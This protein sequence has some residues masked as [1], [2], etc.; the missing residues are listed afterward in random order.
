MDSSQLNQAANVETV[1][2]EEPSDKVQVL[3]DEK[4]CITRKHLY[5]I[6]GVLLVAAIALIGTLLGFSSS[7]PDQSIN[8]DT[9]RAGVS[10][11]FPML[12]TNNDGYVDRNEVGNWMGA[13]IASCKQN[14]NGHNGCD[15]SCG[16]TTV[17]T[18]DPSTNNTVAANSEIDSVITG[19]DFDHNGKISHAE[20]T[21]CVI[22][23]FIHSGPKS[24]VQPSGR[25]EESG[26]TTVSE[27]DVAA[28]EGGVAT[29]R[30]GRKPTC[31]KGLK[32]SC[33]Q[34]FGCQDRRKCAMSIIP[35]DALITE[36]CCPGSG[37]GLNCTECSCG[38]SFN[39]LSATESPTIGQLCHKLADIYCGDRKTGGQCKG[40]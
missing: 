25:F 39:V 23:A 18:E 33:F 30:N 28:I 19:C 21:Q 3:S 4:T 11:T 14:C 22:E 26:S 31:K 17:P 8:Q 2:I 24:V 34:H 32:M 10:S 16:I 13:Q 1:E 6:V 35:A 36:T 12:D 27:C 15:K 29:T 7:S 9:L 37:N 20:M 5:I 38:A 40:H